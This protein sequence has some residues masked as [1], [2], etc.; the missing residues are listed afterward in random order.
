MVGFLVLFP[1]LVLGAFTWLVATRPTTLYATHDFQSDAGFVDALRVGA[2]IAVAE[3][4]QAGPLG[5]GDVE[6]ETIAVLVAK[7][8]ASQE[9]RRRHPLLWVDDNPNNNR[10]ERLAFDIYGFDITLATSTK[11]ALDVLA[12]QPFDLIISDMNR[13]EGPTEGW[14]LLDRMRESGDHTPFVIYSSTGRESSR[15]EA[16]RRGADDYVSNATDLFRAV[17]SA[18]EP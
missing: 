4:T 2:N 13:A 7:A 5:S 15:N 6:A 3:V 8:F 11:D 12:A 1:I 18:I 10:Y 17:T 16:K 14:V 9:S